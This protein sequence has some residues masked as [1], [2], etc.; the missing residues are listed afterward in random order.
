MLKWFNNLRI[1]VRIIIGFLIIVIISC[2]T[3]TIG[4]LNLRRVQDSY[5]ADYSATTDALKH[6]ERISSRFQQARVNIFAYALS[7][8]NMENREYYINRI[9]QHETSVYDHINSYHEILKDYDI[10][11][12]EAELE[13]LNNAET[14]VSEFMTVRKRLM[15]ELEAGSVSFNDFISKFST[16]GE[17]HVL[18]TNADSAI[19]GL[20]NYNLQYATNR[21]EVNEAQ[22]FRSIIIMNIIIVIGMGVAVV[23]SLII[24]RSISKPI[25]TVVSAADRLATGDMD[26]T[27]DI[28]YK[29]ETGK[30]LAAFRN[31]IESTKKQSD[32]IEKIADGDLAVDVP[33]RSDKDLLGRKLNEMVHS[34]NDLIANIATAADQVSAGASQISDSSLGLSQ[35]AAEQASSIE[36]LNATIEEIS[37]KTKVN[38]DNA[39]EASNL[40]EK[41]K[42]HAVNG[43][44]R[45]QDMLNAMDEINE[46]SSNIS[47]IVK[48]I[49]DIAFQ[50][51]ILALNAAVEA[52]RAGQEGRGF[53]VVAEEVRTL[54]ERS[55]NAAK[56]TTALIEESIRKSEDGTKIAEE[57]AEALA[58]IVKEVQ[59]ASGIVGDIKRA[60]IE[61]ATAIDQINQSITQVSQVV[62]ENSATS[63]EAAAA[64]EELSSQAEVLKQLIERFKLRDS[65]IKNNSSLN[66]PGVTIY[67]NKTN[68][69][70]VGKKQKKAKGKNKTDFGK[71]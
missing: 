21:I 26:I 70:N 7:Y 49:D 28:K 65:S 12:I 32:I 4:I 59:T 29:D 25:N 71:Y 69:E 36:E 1:G 3:G 48:L 27:F 31:L 44:A 64:S 46:S 22:A 67:E 57:T 11:E 6:A 60:S 41:T 55:A 68:N 15:D 45:M 9:E 58:R 2:T 53:A 13:M 40:A 37:T 20:T 33:I 38:A 62:H 19:Q 50:T 43:N 47:K 63:E 39:N 54:A 66:P 23:T 10:S 8:E 34:I 16:G 56:E 18:A 42:E 17:A 61:Q 35:G 30:L 52:A 24:S 14:A 5:A 51:N